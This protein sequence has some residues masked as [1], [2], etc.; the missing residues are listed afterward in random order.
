MLYMANL[1]S[2]LCHDIYTPAADG[3]FSWTPQLTFH[4]FQYVEIENVE[5]APTLS[6]FTGEVL[7]DNMA[8]LGKF[9]TSDT[10][11]NQIYKNAF[12]GIRGNYRSIPTDCPQ[13][14]ER[15]GWLG[16][17]ATGCYGEAFVFDNALLYSKWLQDIEESQH[18][19]GNIS[20]VSPR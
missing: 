4:G 17:R 7:Y 8:T 20:A 9:S 10:T 15:N 12:W 3:R 11:I 14:D 2:A 13:R 5:K 18:E 1:R 16:D 19:N 6:D